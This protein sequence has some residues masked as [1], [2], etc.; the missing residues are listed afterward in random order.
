MSKKSVENLTQEMGKLGGSR[1]VSFFNIFYRNPVKVYCNRQQN[2]FYFLYRVLCY[3]K[4]IQ[5]VII[6]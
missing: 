6:Q 1:F 3:H 2:L 4:Q 5:W